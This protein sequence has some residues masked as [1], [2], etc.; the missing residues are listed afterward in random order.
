MAIPNKIS[1]RVKLKILA[2]CN[3]LLDDF[4]HGTIFSEYLNEWEGFSD[5]E[6]F[7]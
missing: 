4:L 1:F 6:P 7:I 5:N 3:V 2:T